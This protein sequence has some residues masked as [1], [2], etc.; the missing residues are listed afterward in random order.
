MYA[1]NT[2]F[3]PMNDHNKNDDKFAQKFILQCLGVCLITFATHFF[4]INVP[5]WAYAQSII[6]IVYGFSPEWIADGMD[7]TIDI[8]SGLYLIIFFYI[9]MMYKTF[10]NSKKPNK[11]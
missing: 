5:I 11:K 10:K 1:K 7:Y 4:G 9:K 2:I 8:F 3:A 6:L